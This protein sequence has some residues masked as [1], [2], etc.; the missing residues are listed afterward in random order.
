LYQ[1]IRF[2]KVKVDQPS[3][4]YDH[5][6]A[7]FDYLGTALDTTLPFQRWGKCVIPADI[8]LRSRMSKEVGQASRSSRYFKAQEGDEPIFGEALAFYSLQQAD[9]EY[10]L[11][12]YHKLLKTHDV[13]GRW[14]G[15]WSKDPIVMETY[16]LSKLVGIWKHKERVHVLRRH[17]GLDLLDLEAYGMEEQE[18]L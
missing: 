13:Y 15:K 16:R 18:E 11:V 8:T 17:V 6:A 14:C 12:V 3:D 10:S 5:L 7:I 9:T 1:S 4:H 2:K